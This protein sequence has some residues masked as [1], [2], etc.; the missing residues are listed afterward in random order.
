[1]TLIDD[2]FSTRRQ[3]LAGPVRRAESEGLAVSLG[4]RDLMGGCEGRFEPTMKKGFPIFQYT[5][6]QYDIIVDLNK[7]IPV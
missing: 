5:L 2:A 1:M 6:I 3:C 4:L 7:Y